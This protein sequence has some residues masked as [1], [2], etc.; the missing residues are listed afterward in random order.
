MSARKIIVNGRRK[1]RPVIIAS[2]R[3]RGRFVCKRFY[4]FYH[5]HI[6]AR[7]PPRYCLFPF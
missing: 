6:E 7:K 5:Q 1:R 2:W 4:W 3:F